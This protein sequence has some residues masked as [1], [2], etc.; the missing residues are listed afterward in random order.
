MP[1]V[2]KSQ[3]GWFEELAQLLRIPSISADP[4]HADD[5]RRAGEWVC[6]FVREAGGTCDLVDWHGQPLAIGEIP[7]SSDAGSAPTVLCYGHFDVQ[8]PDPLELWES[9]P[10][11]PEV[12]GEYLYCRGVADDKGQLYLLLAAAR[13]LA[14][15]GELPV[16]VRFCCDGEEETGGHSIVEF[17]EQ[18]ERGADAAVIFDSGMI[19]R[20][21][22]AFNVATRGLAYFHVVLRTGERDLH[23]GMYGGAALNAAHALVRTLDGL[24][25]R[26]G[27]LAE[28][29]R[30]GVAAP[31]EEELAGWRELPAGADELADQGAR[32]ADPR[33]AE[34]FYLRTFAEPALDVNGFRSGSPDLQKTVLP[35]EAVANLS[36]RLAPG[37]DVEQVAPTVERLLREAAP[38]GA[39]L[40]VRLL[41]SSPPGLVPPDA[42]AI[43]LGLDAFERALGTRPALIRSGGTLPIVP[44]LADKGIPTV[45]TGFSLPDANIH[46]PNERLL[47]EYVDTGIDA[48]AELFRAFAAL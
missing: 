12:R 7:A 26:D 40:D 47:V 23:S 44:A 4:A 34:E 33:A 43:R 19:R 2:P 20:G 42:P 41:S 35:V 31:T 46:S 38:E 16:N 37:Q 5:V 48:A 45:I 30:A 32:A 28:P 13:R 24:L 27:R 29:L 25:A 22:P 6:S 17:L 10:F 8:P 9:D 36:I 1:I 14:R 39:E 21:L 15:A 3:T 11:E 18:D